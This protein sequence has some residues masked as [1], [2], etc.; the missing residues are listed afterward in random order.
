[1]V[2]FSLPKMT[3]RKN[4]DSSEAVLPQFMTSVKGHTPCYSN[5]SKIWKLILVILL[6]IAVIVL[7]RDTQGRPERLAQRITRPSPV[8]HKIESFGKARGPL[9]RLNVPRRIDAKQKKKSVPIHAP[10]MRFVGAEAM[11]DGST[12]SFDLN[13]VLDLDN[14]FI[15]L[16]SSPG[17]LDSRFR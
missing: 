14:V 16:N 5:R 12:V 17:V 2:F 4:S 3:Y 10:Q 13:A 9:R 6:G 7:F 1:M 15:D 11:P 8:A